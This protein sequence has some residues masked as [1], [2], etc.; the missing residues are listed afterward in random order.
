MRAA[1]L[2]LAA[3]RGERMGSGEPKAFLRLAGKTLLE[4]AVETIEACPEV[5]GFV[6]A[7][8]PGHEA[9]AEASVRSSKLVTVVAGGE[10]RQESVRRALEVLPEGFDA[11]VCHD[12]ARP[13]ARPALFAEV[14]RPLREEWA[15]GAVPV[16]PIVDSVKRVRAPDR[17][18]TVPRDE[19]YAAQ[20]PQAFRVEAL[21][22]AHAWIAEQGISLTD[23][24][25]AL[26]RSE[27]GM[28]E[29]VQGDHRNIKITRPEDIPVA[30][31]LLRVLDG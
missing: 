10:T 7:V 25:E 28:A 5:E 18:T 23:D 27:E 21:R 2:L 3:G 31:A 13:L 4:R 9:V 24:A 26:E 29:P 17:M 8:P 16:V 15:D 6:V 12:V 14:L 20:T 19:L 30:E 22:A 11:V 1:A